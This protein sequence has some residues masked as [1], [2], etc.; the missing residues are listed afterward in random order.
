MECTT[1]SPRQGLNQRIN[2]VRVI[3]L[4]LYQAY[5]ASECCLFYAKWVIFTSISFGECNLHFYYMQTYMDYYC[6]S[7]L[8]QQSANRHAATLDHNIPILSQ[9]LILFDTACLAKKQFFGLTQP[10]L[11]PW[12]TTLE[13]STLTNHF[14]TNTVR[15]IELCTKPQIPLLKHFILI[16]LKEF[17]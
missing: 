5:W 8:K 2:L 4:T 15:H 10:G 14:P 17:K 12:S 9:T 13:A 11:E 7:T 1:F 6:A 3:A 16:F